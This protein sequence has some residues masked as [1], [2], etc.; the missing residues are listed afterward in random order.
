MTWDHQFVPR[1]RDVA[2]AVGL[3]FLGSAYIVV[4]Y[5]T[6]PNRSGFI[7]SPFW[8][9]GFIALPAAAFVAGAVFGQTGRFAAWL[10]TPH[11]LAVV[12]QGTVWYEGGSISLF[13]IGLVYPA[14]Q[15]FTSAASWNAGERIR[16]RSG[17]QVEYVGPPRPGDGLL[18]GMRGRVQAV[19]DGPGE[20][21]VHVNWGDAGTTT[22]LPRS[23]VARVRSGL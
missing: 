21:V 3:L 14:I 4:S 19:W 20:R 5:A 8:L 10:V 23:D 18:P 15:G 1:R 13:P 7:D 22:T 6:D 17:A 11:V 2:L 16:I 12:I 9:A